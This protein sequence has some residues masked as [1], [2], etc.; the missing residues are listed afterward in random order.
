LGVFHQ[1][2]ADVNMADLAIREEKGEDGVAVEF[3]PCPTWSPSLPSRSFL[4]YK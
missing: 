2:D 4:L 3:L 1:P